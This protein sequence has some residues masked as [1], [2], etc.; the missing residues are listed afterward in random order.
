MN[1]M[2]EFLR[3]VTAAGEGALVISASGPGGWRD[4]PFADP[5]AACEYAA[6]MAESHDVYFALSR[7]RDA[8]P[9]HRT[10][11]NA[12][13]QRALWADVDCGEG[14][15]YPGIHD[16]L[17]ALG[18]FLGATGLPMPLVVCSGHG[19]HLYWP[20]N[21]DIP[22][23]RWRPLAER[24]HGVCLRF[25]FRVDPSRATD[26]ASVLRLPGTT[27][28]K[29]GG[30]AP[31]EVW[32]DAPASDLPALEAL[33]LS[34]PA[35]PVAG[36]A[37]PAPGLAPELPAFAAG[38]FGSFQSEG[39]ERDWQGVVERC[40]QVREMGSAPYPAWMLAARVILRTTGGPALVHDLSRAA[41]GRYDPRACDRLIASLMRQ[42]GFPP[43]TC[44]AFQRE[45]PG[46]CEGCPHKGKINTP[47]ALGGLPAPEPVVMAAS[48][49]ETADLVGELEVDTQY[50][51]IEIM[52]F[53]SADGAWQVVPGQGIFHIVE[54]GDGTPRHIRVSAT[55]LYIHTLCVDYSGTL[56][57][58]T[59]IMRK[60]A[61]GRAAVDMPFNIADAYGPGK[62]DTWLA[63][64]GL[65]AGPAAQKSMRD[66]MQTYLA[67]VQNNLPELRVRN[68]FGWDRDT[69]HATGR[70]EPCLIIGQSSYSARGERPVRLDDR[71]RS[72]A[73]DFAERGT[74][75]G[76]RPVADLYR[77]LGQPF[78][79]LMVCASFGAPLM[80]AGLGTATNVAYS[81]WDAAGG[82]G[83]S[84]VLRACASVWGDPSRLLMGR[85]DTQAARFQ[86]F[87]VYHNLPVL[88]DEITSMEDADLASML[89]DIV[90]GREKARSTSGGGALM[91]R[92]QWETVTM[93]T[94][95]T[96]V[97][98]TLREFR[99]QTTATA[100]RVIEMQCDFRDY[101]GLP[102]I[103]AINTALA[104]ARANYGV[105]GRVF[106][107]FIAG[108]PGA[109]G[110]AAAYAERFATTHAR[111]ADERFWLFGM[112]IPLF[113]GRIAR[114]LGLVSYDMDALERWCAGT[115]LPSLREGAK[116]ERLSGGD[117]MAAFLNDHL[118]S[119]LIVRARSRDAMKSLPAATAPVVGAGG[120][121]V[122]P[123]VVQ[124]PTRRL[125]I[126]REM[127]SGTV[128]VS[129]RAL[130]SWAKAHG[131]SLDTMLKDL[132]GR[133]CL[134]WGA[135]ASRRLLG[136]D[137]PAMPEV[138]ASVF[139]L[140]LRSDDEEKE[141]E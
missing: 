95:N 17:G 133:G 49:M 111:G 25:G 135:E 114:A 109:L 62:M 112:A 11:A 92:G 58:R 132:S 45:C 42:P 94:S 27:N 80:K 91:E 38:M 41:P 85:N 46:R 110:G 108:D 12:L 120:V 118:D 83:K 72:L 97:Y 55:E 51:T 126:R 13:A 138:R 32:H 16:A 37:A 121:S 137:V 141:K 65:L 87:A 76:W 4:T 86:H 89:Y 53:R 36:A 33:L 71:A 54:D 88:I 124:L 56:A 7:F 84:S 127:D 102:E 82:K 15:D 139:R 136:Q 100:M 98:E 103:K 116:Q 23:E 122:D 47:W 119:T 3:R 31:V 101:T 8:R 73:Q 66:F 52:P 74:V 18:A 28:H 113:A 61:P 106:A 78:A 93:L 125:E 22:T 134:P 129:T 34:L 68:R 2:E 104:A 19:L 6:S 26:A 128:Y 20:L 123:Y 131:V 140:R 90:N 14:K 99:S 43:S 50:G 5:Q 115:L 77:L 75:E 64:C 81:L 30:R 67:A 1:A 130:R 10:Q 63:Q 57:Q 39:G 117:L 9:F 29:R 48:A 21:E 24:L 44:A 59:Y 79:Q 96:G 60:I 105:A 35:D 69:D 70:A 107:R 40:R